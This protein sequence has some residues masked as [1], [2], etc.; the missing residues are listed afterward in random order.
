LQQ[1]KV[2]IDDQRTLLI[3]M[4]QQPGFGSLLNGERNISKLNCI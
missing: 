1:L 2:A 3:A 4:D